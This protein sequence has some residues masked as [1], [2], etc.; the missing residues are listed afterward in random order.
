[1]SNNEKATAILNKLRASQTHPN[2]YADL[3]VRR[4][5]LFS[6]IISSMGGGGENK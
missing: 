1:M 2:G 4:I 5:L 3:G 6:I